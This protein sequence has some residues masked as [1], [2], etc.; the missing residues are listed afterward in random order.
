VPQTLA[1]DL[2]DSLDVVHRHVREAFQQRDLARYARYL[3]ADL[4][5]SDTGGRVQDRGGLLRSLRGQFARLVSFDSRFD[6]ESLAMEGDDAVETGTQ[7]AEIALRVLLIF[8]VRW[9][10]TRH[11]RYTWRRDPAA[12]WALRQVQVDRDEIRREGIGLAGRRPTRPPADPPRW[13]S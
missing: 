10:I 8:A 6:R 3:A 12:G 4:R 11:G 5:F 2:P 13:D 1:A 7:T 9:R